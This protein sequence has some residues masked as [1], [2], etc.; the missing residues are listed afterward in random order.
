MSPRKANLNG[1][2]SVVDAFATLRADYNMAKSSRFRRR[3]TGV[4]GSGTTGDYHYRSESQYLTMM[5]HARDMDRND[6]V[7]GQV[8]DRAVVNTIRDGISVDPNTG[9]KKLDADLMARWQAFASEPDECDLAGEM[10][11]ADM[12]HAALRQT[13]VDG[14]MLVLATEDGPLQ[15]IEG[16]RVRTPSNTK[17]NVVHGVLIDD[18]RRRLEYW[19]TRDELDPNQRLERVSDVTR[20]A[21][22]DGDGRRQ[23]FHVYNPKRVSQTRGITAFAPIVDLMGMFDDI[24][25]AK[26]VQ[27][28]IVSCFATFRERELDFKGSPTVPQQGARESQTLSDGTTRTLEGIGPGMEIAGSPGEKLTGF[29]PNVPNPEFFPHMKI[30]LQL[31]GVN[32]GLPLVLVLLDASETNFSG[33]RGAVDQARMGFQRNQRMIIN[34]LV[35]PS[36]RMMVAQAMVEDAALREAASRSKIDLFACQ[37]TPPNWPYIDPLKDASADL[38]RVRNALISQRRRC[39]ERGYDWDV[40]STEIVDDNALAIEKAIKAAA[41]VNKKNPEANVH[42]RE[43]ISLPTPDGVQVKLSAAPGSFNEDAVAGTGGSDNA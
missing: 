24:M 18:Y 27:Q 31:I 14:D 9:D 42:W 6:A 33:W 22:R 23:V 10:T 4:S 8:V 2:A 30:V 26:L 32:L 43:L 12:Q 21:V 37:C 38:L 39:A 34:R 20:Y 5:E 28:Q 25:F 29:S 15:L 40:I 36:Y 16:H 41:R 1:G 11:H 35:I 7:V 13:L 17:Q 3:R 19:V